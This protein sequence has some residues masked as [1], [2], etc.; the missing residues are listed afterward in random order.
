MSKKFIIR[1]ATVLDAEDIYYINKT[2]LGYDYDFSKQKNKLETILNDRTQVVF[3]PILVIRLW[4]IFILQ[5][6]M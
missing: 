3:V 5:I 6:T 2:S 1:K 4:A